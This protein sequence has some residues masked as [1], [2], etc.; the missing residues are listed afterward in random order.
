MREGVE[1][2]KLRF[3]VLAVVLWV[4]LFLGFGVLLRRAV[5]WGL[6]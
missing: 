6:T 2:M 3:V 4:T 5:T 1:S